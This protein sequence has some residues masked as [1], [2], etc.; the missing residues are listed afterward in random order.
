MIEQALRDKYDKQ[1]ISVIG[2]DVDSTKHAAIKKACKEYLSYLY[3]RM[4]DNRR[5][6]AIKAEFSNKNL[7]GDDDPNS[8]NL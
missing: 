6:K 2:K 7:V 3:V 1:G 5:Y 8:N 4:S